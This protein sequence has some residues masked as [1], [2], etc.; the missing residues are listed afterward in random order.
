MEQREFLCKTHHLYWGCHVVCLCFLLFFFSPLQ[1]AI[2]QSDESLLSA[3]PSRCCSSPFSSSVAYGLIFLSSMLRWG[4]N[5]VQFKSG[6]HQIE[7]AP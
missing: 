2:L 7:H 4:K 6:L 5:R 1:I 3:A